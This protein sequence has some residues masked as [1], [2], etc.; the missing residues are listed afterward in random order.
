MLW[1]LL[2]S[3]PMYWASNLCVCLVFLVNTWV[4]RHNVFL[5]RVY[6]CLLDLRNG[7]ESKCICTTGAMY[8]CPDTNADR[9]H[10]WWRVLCGCSWSH[11]H[12]LGIPCIVF[13]CVVLWRSSI[14]RANYLTITGAGILRRTCPLCVARNEALP[15]STL[16]YQYLLYVHHVLMDSLPMYYV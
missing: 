8:T 7:W 9:V 10:I 15:V 5:H 14:M 1:M 11:R 12:V 6:G 2:T 3:N 16:L 4:T 13:L